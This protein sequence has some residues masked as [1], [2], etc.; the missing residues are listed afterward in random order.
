MFFVCSAMEGIILEASTST[1]VYKERLFSVFSIKVLIYFKYFVLISSRLISLLIINKTEIIL[2]ILGPKLFCVFFFLFVHLKF[3]DNVLEMVRQWTWS[4][5]Y[6][7]W[8]FLLERCNESL[9]FN[10]L[11]FWNLFFLN[12][13]SIYDWLF[14]LL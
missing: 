11:L 13:N 9:K 6:L 4:S 5:K 10:G 1:L 12:F 8:L 3:L 14:F 2:R 7:N